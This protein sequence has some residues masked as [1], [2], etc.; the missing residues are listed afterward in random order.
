MI[1]E[2][3]K[4]EFHELRDTIIEMQY[5]HLNDMQKKAVLSV[6]GPVL[7]LAG[8]GSGK[9]TVLVNRI[10]HIIKY[11]NSYKSNYCPEDLKA[12]DLEHMREYISQDTSGKTRVL[13]HRIAYL[14]REKGVHPGS[15]LAITFTNKAANEMKE[16]VFRML[17]EEN[18][19]IWVSTFHSACV[20]ILRQDAEKLGYGKNFVIYDT[21]NQK[22]LVKDCIREMNLSEKNYPVRKVLSIISGAKDKLMDPEE[23]ISSGDSFMMEQI[24]RIYRLYQ[25]KLKSNNAMDFDDLILNTIL[26]FRLHPDVLRFYQNKF[27][28]IMVDEYQD[29]NIPQYRLVHMLA[30]QHG[31]L[32]VVGDDDQSIYKFRGANIG[33]IL[34]FEK[35][36]PDT[37]V[38]RLEQ[39][40]RSTGNILEAANSV[41]ANNTQRKGKRLWTGREAGCKVLYNQVPSAYEEGQ[42]VASEVKRLGSVED[43]QCSDIAVLYRTNAQSRVLE[44][45]FMKEKIPYRI[46]GS[47]AFYQR[48]EIKDVLAYLQVIY[49]PDDDIS[50]KRIVNEPRRGIGTKTVQSLEEYASRLEISLFDAMKHAGETGCVSE[51]PARRVEDFADMVEHFIALSRDCPVTA[52][53]SEVLD[54]TGYVKA[55]EDEGTEEARSRIENIQELVSAAVQ[56]EEN[57]S[58][59][60]TLQEFL[61]GI[62][63]V[64]GQDEMDRGRGVILMTMHSAKGLEFPVVFITGMEEGVFP[65]SRAMEDPEE[66]E[67]ER[68]LCYVGMTRAR[69]ILYLTCARSRMLHG[70]NSMNPPSRFIEE[71]PAQYIED[72]GNTALK[73]VSAITGGL[74]DRNGGG[75][76]GGYTPGCRI[77]HKIWG[78]GTVIKVEEIK[79]DR[80][81]TVAF[82]DRGVKKLLA[83]MAP[84]KMLQ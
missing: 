18:R 63:L 23:F 67:E 40:Y 80:E 74:Y 75:E 61:E 47:L 35:D 82:P 73:T 83:S 6:D 78:P 46:V 57:S 48:K 42:F 3:M 50:L 60:G 21:D 39:N 13:T 71:I 54:R 65:L 26:L 25:R 22:R 4:K 59:N 30:R 81:I 62:A 77:E 20:R 17:G 79:G 10:A 64:S 28:Y 31:N 41:I 1:S 37:A 32:C 16:R 36:Y 34:G 12:E 53:L 52:L 2:Q 27:R 76:A 70:F 66:L 58:G 72:M 24:G 43:R 19:G 45:A 33:N 44:E 55:L 51:G 84:I 8:A 7:V 29:T 14:I 68:R 49:N 38:I 9:T 69:E 11:G 15:I 56:F 5:A